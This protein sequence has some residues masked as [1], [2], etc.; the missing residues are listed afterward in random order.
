MKRENP[1]FLRIT[2]GEKPKM[3]Q[4]KNASRTSP[5][6]RILSMILSLLFCAAALG[7]CDKPSVPPEDSTTA[8]PEDDFA[9]E[10]ATVFVTQDGA[11]EKDGTSPENAAT[12]ADGLGKTKKAGGTVVVCGPLSFDEDYFFPS[13]GASVTLTSVWE[14]VDYRTAAGAKLAFSSNAFFY[15][16]YLFDGLTISAEKADLLFCLQYNNV[17]FGADVEC[18]RA[19]GVSTDIAL[20]CGYN[21]PSSAYRNVEQV[22][23]HADAAVTV[24]GGSWQ[25]LRGGNR[26]TQAKSTFGTV[27]EG[28]TFAIFVQGGSFSAAS[29]RDLNSASGMNSVAGTVYMEISGG[30]FEGPVYL[31]SRT[32]S[33][34]ELY[35][36]SVTGSVTLKITGGTFRSKELAVRQTTSDK[37][38]LSSHA[39]TV[40]CVSGGAFP[41]GTVATG[42][43]GSSVLLSDGVGVTAK[44][45]TKT[46]SGSADQ[47][48]APTLKANA[49]SYTEPPFPET[50][51]KTGPLTAE[52]EKSLISETAAAL[53]KVR[54]LEQNTPASSMRLRD[55]DKLYSLDALR[56]VKF[57][58]MLTGEYSINKTI[59]N[60]DIAGAGG[61]YM[62]DCGDTTLLAFGDCN[63]EGELGKPWRANALAFTT[64][65]DYTDGITLDGFYMGDTYQSA[66][67]SGEFLL[68]GH[69]TKNKTEESKIPTGGIKIGDTLYF[70]YMSVASWRETDRNGCWPCNYGGIAK[71]T[72]FGRSWETPSDLRWPAG[73]DVDDP[74]EEIPEWGF[75]QLYPV[76][77][78]DFV[79]F[80]GVPG[81]R[82]GYCRLMRVKQS[83][84]ENFSAYEYMTGRDENGNAIFERGEK[85]MMTNCAA[86]DKCVGG[87]G[88][89]YNEYLGEWLMFYCTPETGSLKNSIV[90]RAA[91]TLDGKWSEA[92]LV[93]SQATFGAVY[94]PR[95][96]SAYTREGGRYMMLI[97]S[98]WDIYNSIIWEIEL[99]KKG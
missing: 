60:Y 41:A 23:C 8:L 55:P 89:M 17:T 94:E 30:T 12:L 35:P 32:G 11:G 90:M 93:M 36:V 31:L 47:I 44:S 76:L 77:S 53:A 88:V 75:A 64:D 67:F 24:K 29:G 39:E 96:C 54:K 56:S 87:V 6:F 83:Q 49:P 70:C 52:E 13:N 66:P 37:T 5:R 38:A 34:T 65:R 3:K 79:Y 45:F 82:R 98:R 99:S 22:S 21:V 71:S 78:G 84:I 42:E 81:G 61:G 14:G 97:T 59:T 43:S 58:S 50:K 80:F 27:D 46:L 92:V 20:I 51:P 4:P 48:A 57:V 1:L 85:A 74:V 68:S 15:G 10:A 63:P 69:D 40:L 86:V 7:S 16:D 95:V 9:A 26:R 28:V 2:Q 25:Y 62:I 18:T 19:S 73:T 33:N 72:D 91:K